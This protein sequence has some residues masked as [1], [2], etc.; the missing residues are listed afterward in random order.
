MASE[1]PSAHT[2]RRFSSAVALKVILP[3]VGC[4]V[5][6]GV[7]E[8]V[9]RLLMNGARSTPPLM[10]KPKI[11]YMPESAFLTRD[12]YYPPEKAAGTFRIVAIGDSFTFGGK[13]QFDDTFPKRLER[14]L[15]LN[16]SQRKV[17]V[18]NWGIP[19]YS[20]V[21]EAELFEDAVMKFNPDLIVVEIT[22]NDA[23][24]KP[25][26]VTHGFQNKDG[27]VK[28][29]SSAL[30]HWKSLEFVVTRIYNTILQQE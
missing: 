12:F 23:E 13:V 5:A 6:M 7:V 3:L 2:S 19:G 27:S 16:T 11:N 8:V 14:M 26:Q 20:T 1:I 17:E 22:L 18:L 10:D 9:F 21:Q 4:L 24:L 25:F 15:N 29:A 28:V 30:R